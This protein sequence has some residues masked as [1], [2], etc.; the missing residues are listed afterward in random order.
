MGPGVYLV[1]RVFVVALPPLEGVAAKESILSLCVLHN[2]R[3]C[4]CDASKI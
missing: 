3:A 1:Y 4:A 2:Y